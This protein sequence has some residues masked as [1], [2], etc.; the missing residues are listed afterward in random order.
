MADTI[1][2]NN[3]FLYGETGERLQYIKVQLES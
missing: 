3:Y 2:R 1:A